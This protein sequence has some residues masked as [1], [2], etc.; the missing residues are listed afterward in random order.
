[1]SGD[2]CQVP[3][4]YRPIRDCRQIPVPHLTVERDRVPGRRR[5]GPR[6]QG[7]CLGAGLAC[8]GGAESLDLLVRS[9]LPVGL[10]AVG[11]LPVGLLAVGLLAVGL[12]AVGLLP[13]TL[14]PLLGGTLVT[15]RPA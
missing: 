10:L 6:H 2:D 14:G 1:M 12:L 15:L 5:N 9:L 3:T 4:H 7:A 8:R 13:L 11:L